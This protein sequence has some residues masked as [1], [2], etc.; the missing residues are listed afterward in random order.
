MRKPVLLVSAVTLRWLR[1]LRGARL[2]C[3]V[4]SNPKER[5]WNLSHFLAQGYEDITKHYPA[6]ASQL[7]LQ[8]H[9]W[10]PLGP[11]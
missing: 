10:L 4:Q 3:T 11:G 8:T 7:P 6:K 1:G 9:P 5:T 2:E